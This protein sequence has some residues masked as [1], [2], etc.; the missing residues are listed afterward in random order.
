MKRILT[1]IAI[2]LLSIFN[3]NAQGGCQAYFQYTS[4]NCPT[5]NFYDG[6][7][8]DSTQQNFVA[9]WSWSFGDGTTSTQQNPSHTYTSNGKSFTAEQLENA[10]QS[11]KSKGRI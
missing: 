9:G 7:F 10:Y 11:A 6:S 2:P 1:L 3:A 8:A 4:P 5:V